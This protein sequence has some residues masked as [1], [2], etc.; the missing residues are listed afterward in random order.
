MRTLLM[1][2]LL[3]VVTAASACTRTKAED[4]PGGRGTVTIDGATFALSDVKFAYEPGSYFRIDAA[5]AAHADEDCVPGVSSGVSLYGDLPEGVNSPV[6][7]SDKAVPLE[8][9]GDGDDR[10]LC[11]IGAKGLLGVEQGTVTFGRVYGGA[12]GFTFSGDFKRY[13]GE[14]GESDSAVRVTG[15]GTAAIE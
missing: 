3:A 1:V 13:D 11:F 5:D 9:S 6:E 8:F 14:G 10:N 15:S 4:K 7:L 12:I 2:G